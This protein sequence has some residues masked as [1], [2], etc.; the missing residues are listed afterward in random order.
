MGCSVRG[1]TKLHYCHCVLHVE[2]YLVNDN[3]KLCEAVVFLGCKGSG[4]SGAIITGAAH[5]I[6]LLEMKPASPNKCISS[7]INFWYLRG[8]G[9][10]FCTIVYPFWTDWSFLHL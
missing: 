7:S 8:N 4:F 5:G 9:Y 1:S 10:G 2:I 3:L 6:K